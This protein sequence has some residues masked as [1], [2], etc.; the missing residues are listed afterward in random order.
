MEALTT[1]V[2]SV[3]TLITTTMSSIATAL[4]ANDI[5]MMVIGVVIF[6]IAIGVIFSL[7]KKLKRKGN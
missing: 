1:T 3:V 4:M 7:V 2:A 6:G 5:F